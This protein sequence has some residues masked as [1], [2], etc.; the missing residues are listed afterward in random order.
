[1][2]RFLPVATAAIGT[3]VAATVTLGAHASAAPGATKSPA[4]LTHCLPDDFGV[5]SIN[6]KP[7]WVPEY[8]GPSSSNVAPY[9]LEPLVPLASFLT[10]VGATIS[11]DGKVDTF[12]TPAHTIT[13]EAATGA[14][15]LDGKPQETP[16]TP[17]VEIAGTSYVDAGLAADL[18]G[19]AAYDFRAQRSIP[20][21]SWGKPLPAPAGCMPKLTPAQKA[22]LTEAAL[23]FSLRST[24]TFWCT[25]EDF[26]P[27]D[28]TGPNVNQK[29]IIAS[30]A[31][32]ELCNGNYA[33]AATDYRKAMPGPGIGRS[34][35]DQLI[36]S[37]AYVFAE[38]FGGN[39]DAARAALPSPSPELRAFFAGDTCTSIKGYVADDAKVS[40]TPDDQDDYNK[41]GPEPHLAAAAKAV[42]AGDLSGGL[43]QLSGLRNVHSLYDLMI[44]DLYA[45][46]RNWQ[47]TATEWRTAAFEYP[48][49][50]QMEFISEDAWN[51]EALW[52]IYYYRA[53]MPQT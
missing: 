27:F 14:L 47:A 3:F 24:Q 34:G 25:P 42:C 43:A 7:A 19:D 35:S 26:G 21:R 6:G 51:D 37:R 33:A 23:P 17:P 4:S 45:A 8:Y 29:M 44:G 9:S 1:M 28:A 2:R 15:T 36:F 10:V 39:P 40:R 52:M 32:K 12:K 16:A 53:H 11:H 13:I 50:P 38:T 49:I 41:R 5:V 22:L 30:R 46:Q 48:D 20:E 31:G 18:L